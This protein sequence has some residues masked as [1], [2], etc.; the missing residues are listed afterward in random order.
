MKQKLIVDQFAKK[1]PAS[2]EPIALPCS[3]DLA[4][5]L[6]PEAVELNSNPHNLFS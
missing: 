3:Q 6:Y 2:L 4:T 1:F 5:G